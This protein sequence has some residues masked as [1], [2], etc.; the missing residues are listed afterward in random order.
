M[1]S[2]MCRSM[3][4]ILFRGRRMLT[5]LFDWKKSTLNWSII[6][7]LWRS[8]PSSLSLQFFLW[9]LQLQVT[10]SRSFTIP[11]Q[12]L[13][14]SMAV[15]RWSIFTKVEIRKTS[16]FIWLVGVFALVLTSSRPSKTVTKEAKANS[17]HPQSGRIPIPEQMLEFYPLTQPRML[18]QIGQRSWWFTAMEPFTKATIRMQSNTR[19][20]VYISEELSTLVLISNGQT[21]STIYQLLKRLSWQGHLPVVLQSTYGNSI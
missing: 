9:A 7:I 3:L 4:K 18:L 13:N 1:Y 21:I 8:S 16:C 12:K 20:Q 6:S 10:L 14:V 5:V 11:T 15:A 17:A 19:M 2:I